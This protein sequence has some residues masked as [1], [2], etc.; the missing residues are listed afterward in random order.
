MIVI[1]KNDAD[2]LSL[3]GTHIL[4]LNFD[5]CFY[6]VPRSVEQTLYSAVN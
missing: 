1:P 4:V 6:A 3:V 2:T 5:L